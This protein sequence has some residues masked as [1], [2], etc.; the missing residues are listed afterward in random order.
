MKLLKIA[1]CAAVSTVSLGFASAALADGP[2]F[3]FNVAVT[4]DYVFRGIS[5]NDGETAVSGGI[6]FTDSIFY[7]GTWVSQVNFG[8]SVIPGCGGACDPT[9]YENDLYLGLRPTFLG[10]SWDIGD[11]Y[12]NYIDSPTKFHDRFNEVYLKGSE[13]FGSFTLGGQ[14]YYTSEFFGKTGEAEYYEINAAYAL[15]NKVT[16]SGAV[17]YQALDKSIVGISGYTT[18]NVGATYPVTDHFSVDVRYW[19][20]DDTASK[21]YHDILGKELAGDRLA[22][23]LKLTF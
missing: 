20:T 14:F 5:Q 17:D 15:K 16:L 11:I 9:K 18:W 7:A 6:D 22:G 3:A 4:N 19:G 13:T 12:Y 23:T 1:L 8:T 10:I 21:F 2:A